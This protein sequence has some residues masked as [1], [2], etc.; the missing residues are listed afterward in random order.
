MS[1]RWQELIPEALHDAVSTA[2]VSTYRHAPVECLGAID[3]G[4][5]GAV[6]LRVRAGQHAHLLRVEARR[7]PMRNPHQYTCMAIA[8][9]AQ[10]APRLHYV[11]AEAGIVLMDYIEQAPL[12]QFPGGEAGVARALG[13]LAARLQEAPAFP[14]S[15]TGGRSSGGSSAIS[16][17]CARPACSMSIARASS[18]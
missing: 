14:A 13:T 12:A 18:G 6:V 15:A 17:R 2:F 5:S 16:R 9:E 7:L 3:G 4:A 11:D 10:V 8:A 1:A